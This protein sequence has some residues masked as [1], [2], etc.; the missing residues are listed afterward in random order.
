MLKPEEILSA[1]VPGMSLTVEP[2][3][4]PWEQPPQYVTVQE[5]CDFYID[6]LTTN[7]EAIDAAIDALEARVPLTSLAETVMTYSVMKGLHTVDAGI[8]VAPVVVEMLKTYAELYDI[9]Y[10]MYPADL[11]KGKTFNKA[12]IEKIVGDSTAT[13]EEAIKS[14]ETSAPKGLMSKGKM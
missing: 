5:V 9:P 8:L 14:I 4:V 11:M 7:Q 10:V 1:P 13:V 3:S 6:D 2:G 12:M